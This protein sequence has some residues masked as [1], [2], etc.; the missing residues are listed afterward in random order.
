MF[1]LVAPRYAKK[2]IWEQEVAGSNPVAPT[3]RA[4]AIAVAND[5]RAPVPAH[6]SYAV[7]VLARRET[8]H[9]FFRP[10]SFSR[11]RDRGRVQIFVMPL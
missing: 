7:L 6:G 5:F 10:A 3:I 1:H 8:P 9:R 11:A 2:T 4:R